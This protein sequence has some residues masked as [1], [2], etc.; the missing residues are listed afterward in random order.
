MRQIKARWQLYVLL[1]LPILYL[2]VF[3]Y[4]PMG[5]LL[6]AFKR[7]NFALGIFGSPWAGLG[8]AQE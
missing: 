4:G 2:L 1:V 5:G 6:I 8:P 3:Q 7:Y